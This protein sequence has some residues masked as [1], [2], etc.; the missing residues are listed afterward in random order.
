[1]EEDTVCC[2]EVKKTMAKHCDVKKVTRDGGGV[3]NSSLNRRRSRCRCALRRKE[4]R[5]VVRRSGGER[6]REREGE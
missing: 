6:H 2:L 5:E 3:F 4:R 1:M